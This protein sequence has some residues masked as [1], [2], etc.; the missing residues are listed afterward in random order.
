[1]AY[2]DLNPIRAQMGDT[3]EASDY[4]SIQERISPLI[5]LALAIAGQSFNNTDTIVVK[6]L[7]HFEGGIRDEMQQGILFPLSE[8]LQL[9]DWTGR[10][11]RNDNRDGI[12]SSTP[13]MLTR[14]NVSIDQWMID[15]QQFEKVVH[16]RFRSAL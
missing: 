14:L 10:M 11:V 1:M 13:P 3:P 8:Y 9:V 7:L 15:S 12:P 5:D 6:P 16:R 4:T 2:V